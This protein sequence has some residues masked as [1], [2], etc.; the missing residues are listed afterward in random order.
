MPKK[1]SRPLG[2]QGHKKWKSSTQPCTKMH[3]P[4][5][6]PLLALKCNGGEK[7]ICFLIKPLP[8]PSFPP[9]L[10]S[11]FP[12]GSLDSPLT[13]PS[14][15]CVLRTK[16]YPAFN[17]SIVWWDQAAMTY[18]RA[19]NSNFPWLYLCMYFAPHAYIQANFCPVQSLQVSL[20]LHYG[21]MIIFY[22]EKLIWWVFFRNKTSDKIY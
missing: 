1:N 13:R 16:I 11:P 8:P 20:M 2:L 7:C 22:R 3:F 17:P 9:F 6:F 5:R 4:A 21:S 18:R 10:I 15:S 12:S 14:L 19:W